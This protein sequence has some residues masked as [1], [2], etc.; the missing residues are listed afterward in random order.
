MLLFYSLINANVSTNCVVIGIVIATLVIVWD[1][2]RL[3]RIGLHVGEDIV[4]LRLSHEV[5]FE[6]AEVGAEAKIM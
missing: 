5:E 4:D 2:A 1:E 6:K 3:G